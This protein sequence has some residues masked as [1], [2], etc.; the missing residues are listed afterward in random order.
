MSAILC[1][2]GGG[3]WTVLFLHWRQWDTAAGRANMKKIAKD[4]K[5]SAQNI[6]YHIIFVKVDTL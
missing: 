6:H 1:M 2:F 4:G 3:E 5:N